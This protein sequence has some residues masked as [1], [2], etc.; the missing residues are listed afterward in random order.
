MLTKNA[1]TLTYIVIENLKKPCNKSTDSNVDV[2]IKEHFHNL[3]A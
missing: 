1:N 3:S 2:D